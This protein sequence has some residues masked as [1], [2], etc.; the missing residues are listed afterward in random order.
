MKSRRDSRSDGFDYT[1]KTI[2]DSFG[3]TLALDAEYLDQARQT[4][5]DLL[6]VNLDFSPAS[7][8]VLEGALG[9]LSTRAWYQVDNAHLL[10]LYFGETVRR[11]VG[12]S[13]RVRQQP[14]GN[15]LEV[16]LEGGRA[17]DPWITILSLLDE[18]K[19]P[20]L[21]SIFRALT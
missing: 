5:A 11:A 16:V 4:L 3:L 12:G 18:A 13:Y 17:V 2:T 19:Y 7:V 9:K 14:R 8:D 1:P 10:L 20:E 15:Q 21:G 6:Q